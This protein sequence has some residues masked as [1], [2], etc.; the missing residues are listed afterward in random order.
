MDVGFNQTEA[1]MNDPAMHNTEVR[2]DFWRDPN[3][4]KNGVDLGSPYSTGGEGA[5]GLTKVNI[6]FETEI[7][8]P[9]RSE[10]WHHP[11]LKSPNAINVMKLKCTD[12]SHSEVGANRCRG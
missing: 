1:H 4:A 11:S 9:K 8:A 5:I 12:G 7:V 6:S 10:F 3:E 2:P